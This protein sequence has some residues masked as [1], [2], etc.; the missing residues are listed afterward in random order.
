[1]H[2][3]LQ[4]LMDPQ[5][6]ATSEVAHLSITAWGRTPPPEEVSER[7]AELR[8]E[9]AILDPAQQCLYLARREGVLVGVV[10]AYRQAETPDRWLLWALVVASDHRRLGVASVLTHACADY[11]HQRGAVLLVSQTH[12]DNQASIDF[13]EAFGFRRA[14]TF[15]A[16]DGDQLIRFELALAQRHEPAAQARQ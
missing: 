7:A 2:I 1:M 3:K 10:R 6:T 14:G 13:H 11:A 4:L 9:L 15:T 16:T 12:L 5:S 8:S